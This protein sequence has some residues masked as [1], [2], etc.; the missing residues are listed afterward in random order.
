MA[1]KSVGLSSAI[2]HARYLLFVPPEQAVD[3]RKLDVSNASKETCNLCQ[4]TFVGLYFVS[5]PSVQSNMGNAEF[6]CGLAFVISG[7]AYVA[8]HCIKNL[9]CFQWSFLPVLITYF[10]CS[11]HLARVGGPA[12][13]GHALPRHITIRRTV[14]V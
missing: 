10:F 8:L 3:V 9:L 14:N 2:C 1:D 11:C 5:E 13:A 4:P 12:A 7:L 6:D